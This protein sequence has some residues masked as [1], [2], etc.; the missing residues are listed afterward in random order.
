MK[1][2]LI[3]SI[4]L[5][6]ISL[7]ANPW[8]TFGAK[9]VDLKTEGGQS[10]ITVEDKGF[11][12]TVTFIGNLKTEN[13]TRILETKDTLTSWKSLSIQTLQF[14]QSE[15]GQLDALVLPQK[16]ESSGT[17][18]MAYLPAGMFFTYSDIL[19]SDFRIKKDNLFLQIR[20]R[21]INEAE[22][23]KKIFKAIENPAAFI[24]IGDTEY[25]L[26]K[27]DQLEEASDEQ[28][29]E[30]YRLKLS[31]LAYMNRDFF[32]TPHPIEAKVVVQILDLKKKNPAWGKK[33]LA[34]SLQDEKVKIS[35]SE[36]ALVLGLYFNEFER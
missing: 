9:V 3:L 13:I 34:K 19:R 21:I 30:N 24:R 25:Y 36:I 8:E 2:F 11:T 4:I 27:L 18:L 32:G 14:K 29:A 22:L 5:I 6:N 33:E 16:F 12:F 23:L 35:E 10:I 28:K 31:L 26:A 7:Y 15:S 1:V 17:N 20:G